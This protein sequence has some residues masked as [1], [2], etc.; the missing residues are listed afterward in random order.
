MKPEKKKYSASITEMKEY[1]WE[2][3]FL[4][5]LEV[6]FT[7]KHNFRGPRWMCEGGVLMMMAT[8]QGLTVSC[9]AAASHR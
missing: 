9:R 1:F 5:L 8:L 2:N 7:Q 4:T 6:S 3:R